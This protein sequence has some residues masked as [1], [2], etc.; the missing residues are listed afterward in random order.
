MYQMWY[1]YERERF[2]AVEDCSAVLLCFA[3]DKK[4]TFDNIPK[5]IED[6]NSQAKGKII[7]LCGLRSDK[8]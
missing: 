3:I 4:S 7:V 8:P 5:Y 6:I 2:D 1:G